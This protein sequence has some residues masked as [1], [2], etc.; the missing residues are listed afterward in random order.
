MKFERYVN[1]ALIKTYL[2]NTFK[3]ETN[4]FK[5]KYNNT[6]TGV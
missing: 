5:T 1:K 2:T 3:H 6:L 4:I